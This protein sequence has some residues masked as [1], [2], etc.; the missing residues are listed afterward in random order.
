MPI[1]N[2]EGLIKP[3]LHVL[4]NRRGTPNFWHRAKTISARHY[5]FTRPQIKG[6]SPAGQSSNFWWTPLLSMCYSREMADKQL[7]VILHR[8]LRVKFDLNRNRKSHLW[9]SKEIDQN[10]GERRE[11]IRKEKWLF[12]AMAHVACQNFRK[13]SLWV[14]PSNQAWFD[15]ADTEFDEQQWYENFRVTRDTFQFI[16]NEIERDITR[17]NTPMHQAI[18]AKRRLAIVLNNLSSTVE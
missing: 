11:K 7:S 9:F 6:L 13:R 8:I 16:L 2:F 4:K 18:S 12:A 10:L 1:S 15:M 14:R 5:P 3:H 17:W